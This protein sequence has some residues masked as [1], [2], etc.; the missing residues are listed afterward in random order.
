MNSSMAK[1]EITS[2]PAQQ[3]IEQPKA[4]LYLQ[5]PKAEV[6]IQTTPGQF[7]IEQTL[8]WESMDIKH[9]FRRIEENAQKGYSDLLS[10]IARTAT[11]GDE[12]MRIENGGSPIVNQ[13]IKNSKIQSRDY[14][15]G[16]VP[17]PF[18]VKINFAPGNLKIKAYP[19]QV[20]NDPV[21]QK[22]QI[23]YREGEVSTKV[24]QFADL[25]INFINLGI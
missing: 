16:F 21:V 10:G 7:T 20:I 15:I 5:Q 3:S 14:N 23:D 13:A 8:A 25:N 18:S 1:I 11:E 6:K 2:T 17:P 9:I 12:L 22:P 19:K 24:K 4:Q